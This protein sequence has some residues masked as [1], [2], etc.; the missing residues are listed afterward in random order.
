VGCGYTSLFEATVSSALV[1]E[2]RRL[3]QTPLQR[4]ASLDLISSRR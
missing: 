3:S 4:I 2:I 1:F